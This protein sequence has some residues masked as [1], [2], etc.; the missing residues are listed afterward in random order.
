M[1]FCAQYGNRLSFYGNIQ[2]GRY[3]LPIKTYGGWPDDIPRDS[4]MVNNYPIE[5]DEVAD[6]KPDT[7]IAEN[8]AI[9]K[10]L[11]LE[12]LD[13]QDTK[14]R[15]ELRNQIERARQDKVKAFQLAARIDEE[16]AFILLN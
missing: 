11:R 9:I 8:I 1:T 15:M 16:E 7:S 2:Y 4:P 5:S 12:L 10:R 13:T 3:A 6:Q 14:R